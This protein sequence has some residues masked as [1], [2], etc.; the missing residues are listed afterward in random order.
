MITKSGDRVKIKC[1]ACEVLARPI[2]LCAARSAHII[3]IEL[4]KKGLHEQPILLRAHLQKSI[5]AAD[6]SGYQAIL[7][8]Y[9][10]CGLATSGLQA[11]SIPLIIPRAH[12]CITL[13]LGSR[14]RYMEQFEKEPG[15]YWYAQDYI[16]RSENTHTSLSMGSGSDI[17]MQSVYEEYVQK[18]G[19]DN[20]DYLMEVMGAWKQHYHR[21][22]F[23]DM[24]VS[25]GSQVESTAQDEAARRGWNFERLAGDLVLIRRLLDGDWHDDFLEVPPGQQVRMVN[26]ENILTLCS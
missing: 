22:A 11:R 8:G 3:D 6:T 19:T 2:Y 5:D 13:F 16:E 18:Y 7:L 9:G 24:G 4:V 15:T 12:D 17:D 1:I 20:A 26:D 25:D 23:I 14:Q 10:L 21:A